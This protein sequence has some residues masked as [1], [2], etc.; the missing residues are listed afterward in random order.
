MR[1]EIE[2]RI[3]EITEQMIKKFNIPLDKIKTKESIGKVLAYVGGSSPPNFDEDYFKDV[4]TISQVLAEI[5]VSIR[6]LGNKYNYFDEDK[7]YRDVYSITVKRDNKKISFKFGASM[8]MTW[9]HEKPDLYDV[10]TSIQSDWS[11]G[12]E[13]YQEYCANFEV[14]EDSVKGLKTWKK[15]EKQFNKLN[16][17]FEEAEIW[18]M[19]S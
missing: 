6:Y 19:P 16:S 8:Q 7:E 17:M 13:G 1:E 11:V 5:K 3:K 2:P 10:L 4:E 14:S 9:N 15:I 12:N 18:S